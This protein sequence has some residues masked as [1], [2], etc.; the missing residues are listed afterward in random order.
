V[1]LDEVL[2]L[3]REG[4]GLGLGGSV[5]FLP[6]ARCSTTEQ[7]LEGVAGGD[8]SH[9]HGR[10]RSDLLDDGCAEEGKKKEV[11]KVVFRWNFG[12]LEREREFVVYALF[13]I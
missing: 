2:R 6:A 11:R 1:L 13:Y 10:A 4:L 7:D 3:P 5:R 12:L 8:E 9:A